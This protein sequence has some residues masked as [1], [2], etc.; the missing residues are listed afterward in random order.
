MKGRHSFL[1]TLSA[2]ALA[3]CASAPSVPSGNR[4]AV[5]TNPAGVSGC[6]AVGHLHG[7]PSQPL[8][9]EVMRE[10]R[11]QAVG[12]GGNVVFLDSNTPP[13]RGTTYHCDPGS[14]PERGK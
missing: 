9:G 14:L 12:A 10:L 7:L 1:L 4:V 5:M 6:K 13:Y 11:S 3:G 2:A 8:V